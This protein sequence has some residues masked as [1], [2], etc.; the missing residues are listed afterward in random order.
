MRGVAFLGLVEVAEAE[1]AV[2]LQEQ[3]VEMVAEAAGLRMA[4][5]A[6]ELVGI[7]AMAVMALAILA[8]LEIMARQVVAEQVV[9][10]LMLD[11][12]D[13]KLAAAA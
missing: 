11:S 1:L 8:E 7:P 9:A 5:L 3:A 4:V 12:I 6:V 10:G 2:E 13:H